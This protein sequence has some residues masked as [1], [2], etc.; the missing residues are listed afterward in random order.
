MTASLYE[1]ALRI[2]RKDSDITREAW[3]TTHYGDSFLDLSR[4]EQA[5]QH[6]ETALS[7][8]MSSMSLVPGLPAAN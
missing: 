3:I 6:Y 8:L 7:L 2:S 5:I 1:R 4:P